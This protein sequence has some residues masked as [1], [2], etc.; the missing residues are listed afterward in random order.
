MVR[1]NIVIESVTM[2]SRSRIVF[3]AERLADPDWCT[4]NFYKRIVNYIHKNSMYADDDMKI[5]FKFL[6]HWKDFYHGENKKYFNS[7]IK[8][9]EYMNKLGYYYE[10]E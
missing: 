5:I 9:I 1:E 2:V 4:L 6:N 7:I 3:Y 10:E 8:R